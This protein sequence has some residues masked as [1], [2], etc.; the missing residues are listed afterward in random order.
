MTKELAGIKPVETELETQI[1]D[2][3]VDDGNIR[4]DE[5]SYQAEF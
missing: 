2:R 3:V 1:G 5:G 4:Y